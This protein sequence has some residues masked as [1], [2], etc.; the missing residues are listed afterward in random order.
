MIGTITSYSPRK[1]VG[2]I[3]DTY[4]YK[5]YFYQNGFKKGQRVEFEENKDDDEVAQIVKVL[6]PQNWFRIKRYTFFDNLIS[7]IIALILGAIMAFFLVKNVH[8]ETLLETMDTEDIHLLAQLAHAEGHNQDV[9][10]MRYIVAVVL[11][12]LDS[13]I[14]PNTI[15]EIIFQPGQFAVVGNGEFEKSI[16]EES[17]FEAVKQELEHRSNKEILYFTAGNYG[18]FGTPSFKYKEHYFSE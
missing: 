14:F 8:A 7:I 5:Y 3:R 12:R 16:P 11:N 2:V 13:P 17:D 9:D 15:S 1:R 4:G 18:E 10:G 6:Q